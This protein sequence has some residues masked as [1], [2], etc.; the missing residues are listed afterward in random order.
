MG[1][2]WLK[3]LVES[4]GF[5]FWDQMDQEMWSCLPDTALV[6]IYLCL[7]DQDRLNMSLICKNWNNVFSYPC[8]W[9]TRYIELGGY[10]AIS[11]GDRACKF[12]DKHGDHL[13]Y[14]FLSCTH[15]SSHCCKII[16]MTIDSFLTKIEN[17]KLVHFELVRLNLDRFWKF[18]NLK[19]KI[20][21][22][23]ARFLQTQ[24]NMLNF[25]MG[26]A[27]F[28]L[29]SGCRIL[30]AIGSAS[31]SSIKDLDIEDFF[32][33]RLAMFQVKRFKNAFSMFTNL[34]YLSLNYN[35]LSDEIFETMAERLSGKLRN[36]SCTVCMDCH[37]IPRDH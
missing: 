13:R 21:H 29:T 30:E 27:H 10:R 7:G 34:T 31:G 4:T 14:L 1:F 12:A 25:D 32:H 19:E 33:S 36:I 6:E 18:E 2:G 35:C 17:S 3:A 8:L 23:F 24:R 22:S 15:P 16:Q 26:D 37:L 5:T 28:S 20:V 9:R 11:A